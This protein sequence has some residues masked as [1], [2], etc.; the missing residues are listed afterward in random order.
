MAG[1]AEDNSG[2]TLAW[3]CP[4]LPLGHKSTR[5]PPALRSPGCYGPLLSS[6]LSDLYMP[7]ALLAA[8]LA[9]GSSPAL[10]PAPVPCMTDKPSQLRRPPCIW[11]CFFSETAV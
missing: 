1:K 9:G 10:A 2:L 3:V 5:W 7:T 6:A 8:R 11:V 4:S